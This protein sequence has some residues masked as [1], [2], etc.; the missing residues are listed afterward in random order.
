MGA[1]AQVGELALGVEGDDGVLG[2]VLNKL[3]LVG[4][5]F[6]LHVSNGLWA[7]LLAALQVQPLLTNFLHLRLNLI[8]ML[9]GEGEG[10]VEV[11]VPALGN[12]GANG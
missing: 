3:H 12:G 4:L 2:Q 11:V 1:G 8:Q 5:V 6:L 7:G 9:L 10:A